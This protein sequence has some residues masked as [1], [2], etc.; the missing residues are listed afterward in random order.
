MELSVI[1][2]EN[3]NNEQFSMNEKILSDAR[4]NYGMVGVEELTIIPQKQSDGYEHEKGK[5]EGDEMDD[6]EEVAAVT[7]VEETVVNVE[8]ED[9]I[10]M[11]LNQEFATKNEVRD[12]VD[13]GVHSNCFEV[14]IFKSNPVLHVLKCRGV[15]C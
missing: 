11:R 6:R 5:G 10:D 8:W 13:K 4:A 14:D 7:P 15:G 3:Q 9:G 2:S 1:A 12:L